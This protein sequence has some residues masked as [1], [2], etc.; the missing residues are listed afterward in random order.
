MGLQ[1]NYSR[2][3]YT[4]TVNLRNYHDSLALLA[5]DFNKLILHTVSPYVGLGYIVTVTVEITK[6]GLPHGETYRTGPRM[7]R[8]RVR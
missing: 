5:T 6:E 2:V 8:R 7:H 4:D 3:I 1:M